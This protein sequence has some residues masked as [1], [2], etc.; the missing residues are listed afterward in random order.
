MSK[1]DRDLDQLFGEM[2]AFQKSRCGA[3]KKKG[4][5]KPP[6]DMKAKGDEDPDGDGDGEGDDDGDGDGKPFGKGLTPVDL[7]DDDIVPVDATEVL[8]S[9]HARNKELARE[10]SDIK[11]AVST[12]T[13][14]NER[15]L[16][17][18]EGMHENIKTLGD[19]PAGRRAVLTPFEK[20]LGEDLGHEPEPKDVVEAKRTIMQKSLAAVEAGKLSPRDQAQ[21]NSCLN[22]G[23]AIPPRL[24]A[25]MN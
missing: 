15:M 6:A 19:A 16:K 24:R 10:N 12:L 23:W 21:V 17:A 11:S 4:P 13:K 8:K 22:R 7:D 18:L 1:L 25:Q 20:S 14:Q 2:E 3:G 5:A 9:L